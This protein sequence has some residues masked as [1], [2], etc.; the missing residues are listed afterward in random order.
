MDEQYYI[1]S[2]KLKLELNMRINQFQPWTEK[3]ILLIGT[4]LD[5]LQ[6]GTGI[7]ND[8]KMLFTLLSRTNIYKKIVNN[9]PELK[10]VQQKVIFT[11]VIDEVNH[12][13]FMQSGKPDMISKQSIEDTLK[14]IV[15]TENIYKTNK[16]TINK[17]NQGKKV[18]ENTLKLTA[19]LNQLQ[20]IFKDCY[21]YR[22]YVYRD[23]NITKN[24]TLHVI[25]PPQYSKFQQPLESFLKS[26]NYKYVI[27]NSLDRNLDMDAE[28]LYRSESGINM[29]SV[30]F[31]A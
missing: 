24:E 21:V 5:I 28:L 4:A 11:Q 17:E 8:Y 16:S 22:V 6:T 7:N 30:D 10:G 29:N 14:G 12:M 19:M 23:F 20:M 18:A 31:K 1:D 13:L 26:F 15:T 27:H 3:T 25:L 2:L 9:S